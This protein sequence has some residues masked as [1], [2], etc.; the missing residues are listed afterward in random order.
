M[1]ITLTISEDKLNAILQDVRTVYPDCF[2]ED[3]SDDRAKIILR[4]ALRDLAVHQ[5]R[6][7]RQIRLNK[8]ETAPEDII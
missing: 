2:H 4:K 1:D 5:I 7:W 8:S 6:K 3:N